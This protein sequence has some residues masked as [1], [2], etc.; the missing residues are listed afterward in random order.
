MYSDKKSVLQ[1]AALLKAHGVDNI[2]LSPGSRNAPITHTLSNIKYF[3]CHAI[4]DERSA[5][6]FAI[7]L[8]LQLSKPVAVCCTSGSALLNLHPAVAEAF[9]QKVPLI[10]ISADRPAAW[11]GQ[12]DGQTL[13]QANVFGSL[14]KMSVNLPEIENYSE[15]KN[16]KDEWYCNRLINEAIMEASHGESGP[17]HINIP[18]SEPLYNFTVKKLPNV[19]VINRYQSIGI[20]NDEINS[21]AAN[22]NATNG[23]AAN[24]N[25]T[26]SNGA[27]NKEYCELIQRINSYTRKMVI[28]GQMNK[29]SISENNYD[30][31]LRRNFVWLSENLSNQVA[32][33][34]VISNF[35]GAIYSM[36]SKMQKEMSPELVITFGGHIISKQLKRYLREYKPKEH[37]H[38]SQDGKVMDL[39]ESLTLVIEM[40][41]FEFFRIIAPKLNCDSSLYHN[42]W[43]DFCATIPTPQLPYSSISIVGNLI[44]KIPESSVLH[45]ANSSVVRYSQMFT[46]PKNV[47][48]FCNRGV[49]GIDGSLSTAIGYASVSNKLNFILIGDLSFFYDMNALWNDSLKSNMR[50]LLINN[51]GGEIFNTL[52]GMESNNKS[53]RYIIGTHNTSAAGW[54]KERGLKYVKVTNQEEFDK[55]IDMFVSFSEVPMLIEVY[56]NRNTD[57]VILRDYYSSIK[58]K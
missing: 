32:T 6:F 4:T 38:I 46:I 43:S 35:D 9:Y 3:K 13:P 23:S 51:G 21:N 10:V 18:L 28:I 26:N 20:S 53:G 56:T 57:T 29:T 40:N 5:G 49:N 45:F 33:N 25:A 44:K 16:C 52:P 11:I 15:V 48:V 30:N 41:P 42:I 24:C 1:L 47:E 31:R 22:S 17:V 39:F 19:R 34:E 12:M 8:A 36:T 37:W 7:G 50:I 27:S 55:N 2:V 14:V 58:K 54:A